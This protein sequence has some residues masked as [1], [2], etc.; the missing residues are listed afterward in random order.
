MPT[1]S[2]CLGF[3]S[4][5]FPKKTTKSE[6]TWEFQQLRKEAESELCHW[7]QEKR[8]L[9]PPNLPDQ[10]IR[11]G[12]HL[13]DDRIFLHPHKIDSTQEQ[14][15]LEALIDDPSSIRNALNKAIDQRRSHVDQEEYEASLSRLS[16]RCGDLAEDYCHYL[17]TNPNA[18]TRNKDQKHIFFKMTFRNL[19]HE[20]IIATKNYLFNI[21]DDENCLVI[22]PWVG[23]VFSLKEFNDFWFK[24]NNHLLLNER[25]ENLHR[26]WDESFPVQISQ[27]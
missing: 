4:V 12:K 16:G 17:T 1:I 20:C 19:D 11:H 25:R 14:L 5:S 2:A 22:D 3:R 21:H 6:G 26:R 7:I 13:F 9:T 10:K 23:R 8:P 15:S 24:E 27:F 18:L